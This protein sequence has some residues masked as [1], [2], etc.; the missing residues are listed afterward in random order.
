MVAPCHNID[1]YLEIDLPNV[2]FHVQF[3]A[4]MLVDGNMYSVGTDFV[5]VFVEYVVVGVVVL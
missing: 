4:I 3:H 2:F 1:S 5:F